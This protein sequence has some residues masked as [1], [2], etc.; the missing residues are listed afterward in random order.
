[1]TAVHTY[2]YVAVYTQRGCHTLKLWAGSLRD[3]DLISV[4][5]K[6]FVCYAKRPHQMWR[7]LSL[8]F[9]EYRRLFLRE[10]IQR[11]WNEPLICT[12]C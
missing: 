12:E 3:R 10:Q 5:G 6:R 11:A 2:F 9:I 4:R 8:V 7:P 1:M